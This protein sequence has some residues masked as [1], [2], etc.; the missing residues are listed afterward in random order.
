MPFVRAG[1][2]TANT[3]CTGAHGIGTCLVAQLPAGNMAAGKDIGRA[4]QM[5]VRRSAE[6]RGLLRWHH[7]R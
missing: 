1:N 5:A 4:V 3:G 2:H 6:G 7:R